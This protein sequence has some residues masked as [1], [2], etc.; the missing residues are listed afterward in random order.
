VEASLFV[1]RRHPHGEALEAGLAKAE[2]GV[3]KGRS[4]RGGGD[5][6]SEV[7]PEN[8]RIRVDKTRAVT[9]GPPKPGVSP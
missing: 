8:G 7:R 3:P 9:T 1:T 4:G 2:E 6:A 5:G